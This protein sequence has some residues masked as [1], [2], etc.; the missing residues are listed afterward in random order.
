MKL[1][2]SRVDGT[3]DPWSDW[4]HILNCQ[5]DQD[6]VWE[7]IEK[8]VFWQYTR[9]G[10]LHILTVLDKD[11]EMLDFTDPD[12]DRNEFWAEIAE[13]MHSK[14]EA[15]YWILAYKHCKGLYRRLLLLF[16]VGISYSLE[17]LRDFYV[18]KRFGIESYKDFF[19]YK[20]MPKTVNADCHEL[21]VVTGMPAVTIQ[22][23]ADKML[24][25]N[26]LM[27]TLF[28]GKSAE[29]DQKLRSKWARNNPF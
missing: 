14:A 5:N 21:F 20:A 16:D 22:E 27:A 26:A 4:D 2:G 24:A 13:N 19:A 18:Q 29:Y 7:A 1:V 3:C 17:Y 6:K 12:E 8:A 23:R 25:M 15:D 11:C 28:K 10:R 9:K